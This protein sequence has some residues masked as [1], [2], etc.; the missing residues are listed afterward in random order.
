[1]QTGDINNALIRAC[2][3]R[4]VEMVTVLLDHATDVNYQ[5]EVKLNLYT[6]TLITNF[7]LTDLTLQLSQSALWWASITGETECVKVLLKYGAQ[8]DLPVRCDVM[9]R[10]GSRVEVLFWQTGKML[11]WAY[12]VG[13]AGIDQILNYSTL[14]VM[15]YRGKF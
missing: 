11:G 10:N 13:V 3:K 2:A 1:V 5:N 7:I 4:C 14:P 9:Y 8:V 12:G 15:L 6:V